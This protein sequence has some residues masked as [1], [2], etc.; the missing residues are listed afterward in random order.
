MLTSGGTHIDAPALFFDQGVTVDR[1]PLNQ[2]F[3]PTCLIDVS[4]KSE[5]D[6][7]ISPADIEQYEIDHGIIPEHSIVVGF[8]GWSRYWTNPKAYRNEDERGHTHFPTF[9]L[10]AVQLLLK[11]NI[12]GI[13]IDTLALEPLD[14][15]FQTHKILLEAGKYIIE[16]IAN[17]SQLP[18]KGAYILALPLKIE[19]GFEAPAR[20]VG[21]IK[22]S[23]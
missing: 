9:S 8:T 22:E 7:Q 17:A 3:G 5:A 21:L 6:Y 23:G 2:L 1:L 14:S 16:N 4:K 20:V 19:K 11:R 10:S 15:S 13:A 12:A 18:P